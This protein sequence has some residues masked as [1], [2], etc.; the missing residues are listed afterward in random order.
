MN[1]HRDCKKTYKIIIKR[2]N[3]DKL[4]IGRKLGKRHRRHRDINQRLHPGPSLRIPNLTR[5]VVAPGNDQIA[6]SVE[7]GGRDRHRVRTDH[8]HRLP[9]LDVPNP[10]GVVE[11]PGDEEIGLRVEIDAENP[12][13][14][15]AEDFDALGGADEPDAE[16]AVVGGGA[17][18][19]GVG[20]P[21]EVADAV[22]VA[23]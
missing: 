10:N 4:A 7:T 18:V 1:Q 11:A 2:C 23:D 5:A 8:V 3:K 16:G 14:V 13:R 22:G 15:A 9:R 21:G 12:I 20:G 19:G 17:D 6:V